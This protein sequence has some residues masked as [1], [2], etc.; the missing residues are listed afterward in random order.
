MKTKQPI[1][2]KAYDEPRCRS[3]VLQTIEVL[4]ASGSGSL[5]DY[6][7]EDLF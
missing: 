3:F 5:E 1:A 6:D 2:A 4:A 7:Y